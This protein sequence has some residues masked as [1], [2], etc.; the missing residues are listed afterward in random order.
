VIFAYPKL[1]RIAMDVTLIHPADWTKS[2]LSIAHIEQT[3]WGRR[4]VYAIKHH[5]TLV[6]EFFLPEIL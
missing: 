5:Q 4:T 6:S 3:L 1:E 2:V